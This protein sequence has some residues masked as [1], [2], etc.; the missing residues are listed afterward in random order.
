MLPVVQETNEW[1]V[2]IAA[3]S[4]SAFKLLYNN[5][6]EQVYHTANR[7][8]QSQEMAMDALQEI[9]IKIWM[10]REQLPELENFPAWLNRVTRNHLY[11]KLRTQASNISSLNFI[12]EEGWESY[13]DATYTEAEFKELLLLVE[14]AQQQL[15]PQ[16]QKVFNL[17]RLQGLKHKEIASEMGLSVETVK[18]YIMD[19]LQKM[20][21][22]LQQHGKQVSVILLLQ[23]LHQNN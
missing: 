20:R 11:D 2:Q 17:S 7:V 4:Q 18:K 12:Q 5:Y 9:F 15:S 3:G 8:L 1:M 23:L 6:K 10:N 21:I 14:Q 13:A 19:A 16:Q 22:F